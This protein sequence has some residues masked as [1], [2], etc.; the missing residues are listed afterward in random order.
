MKLSLKCKWRAVCAGTCCRRVISNFSLNR[1]FRYT[2]SLW[3]CGT[4]L[5]LGEEQWDGS[6][7]NRDGGCCH[8]DPEEE[9]QWILPSCR[10]LVC[11]SVILKL[12]F[13][14]CFTKYVQY[15]SLSSLV[16]SRLMCE[17]SYTFLTCIFT[18]LIFLDSIWIWTTR[19]NI[20]KCHRWTLTVGFTHCVL[21]SLEQ[22][23]KKIL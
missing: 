4:A 14:L 1:V 8:Q 17:Q 22:T 3:T 16:G 6:F 15:A 21:R 12:S 18:L 23:R 7:A 11:T 19:I 9:P 13:V 10:R 20:T 2:R 5:W